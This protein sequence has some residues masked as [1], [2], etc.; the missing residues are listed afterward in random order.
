M[1]KTL[2]TPIG[3]FAAQI[4]QALGTQIEAYLGIPY[5]RAEA[6]G[7]PEPIDSYS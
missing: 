2:S 4:D 1:N 7:L 6:F 5:A 3:E